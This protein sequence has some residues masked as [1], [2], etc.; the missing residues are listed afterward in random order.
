MKILFLGDIVGR[1]GR[2]IV[3]KYI[4]QLQKDY[5]ID[6]TIVNAENSAHGKGITTKIYHQLKDNGINAI[7]LGNHAFS[8]SEI[9]NTFDELDDLIAPRNNPSVKT[10]GY[11]IYDV[12][13]LKLCVANILGSALMHENANDAFSSMNEIINETDA[14]LYFVDLHAEAT[15]EKILFAHYFKDKLTAV[16]GT[17]TH[18][19]TADERIIEGMAY[20]SDAGMCGVYDSVIGRDIN[21][22]IDNIILHKETRY[23]V[24]EGEAILCGAVIEID[25]TDKRAVD[26]KRIQIRPY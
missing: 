20:L 14:D 3:F 9:L 2:N 16:I 21:E 24:A 11:Q 18:V 23:T 13:G 1:C 4:R 25:E 10:S 5:Q 26:I 19:Q 8:K 12:K 22:M 15:A 17:H 6:F 7:T